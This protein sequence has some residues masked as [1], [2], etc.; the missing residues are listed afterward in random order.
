[1][2]RVRSNNFNGSDDEIEGVILILCESNFDNGKG[3]WP[4]KQQL[5][6]YI[7]G[8]T[9]DISLNDFNAAYDNIIKKG[10]IEE[11]DDTDI[12]EKMKDAYEKSQREYWK[13]YR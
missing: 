4:S 9:L 3:N 11:Y 5:E 7:T 10:V 6:S 1:M 13:D 12:K 8:P 2:I